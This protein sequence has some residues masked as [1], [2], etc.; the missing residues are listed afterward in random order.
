MI[1]DVKT[2]ASQI[3]SG[4]GCPIMPV[5]QSVLK[6]RSFSALFLVQWTSV[7]YEFLETRI[8]LL[9]LA[10]LPQSDEIISWGTEENTD[11]FYTVKTGK[12]LSE[13]PC[14]PIL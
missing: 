7:N 13:V 9:H 8:V 3:R 1:S 14:L 6:D 2:S 5:K 4:R 10:T 11:R 12:M